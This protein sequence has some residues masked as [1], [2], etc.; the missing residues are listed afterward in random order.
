MTPE[1]RSNGRICTPRSVLCVVLES[2]LSAL[3]LYQ[4][5]GGVEDR[6]VLL[7]SLLLGFGLDAYVCV[8]SASTQADSQRSP[9]IT[10]YAWIATVGFAG[11]VTF[12]DPATA[13]RYVRL[14]KHR[15]ISGRL[16]GRRMCRAKSFRRTPSERSGAYSTTGRSSA[17][18]SRGERLTNAAVSLTLSQSDSLYECWFDLDNEVTRV[19]ISVSC[20]PHR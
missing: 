16:A 1:L 12:W 8:G 17:T 11:D 4:G 7:C 19:L 10:P 20:D 18:A 5:S 2:P 9:P 14:N 6:A 13:I 15:C 3:T